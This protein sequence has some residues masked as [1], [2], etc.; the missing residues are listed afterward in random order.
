MLMSGNLCR[1]AHHSD[2]PRDSRV[3]TYNQSH[4]LGDRRLYSATLLL[5]LL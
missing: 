1:A 3:L 5:A 4:V 2:E